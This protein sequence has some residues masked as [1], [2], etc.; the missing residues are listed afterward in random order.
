[1]IFLMRAAVPCAKTSRW[2]ILGQHPAAAPLAVPRVLHQGQSSTTA[3]P[4][5]WRRR[6]AAASNARHSVEPLLSDQQS[7]AS[8]VAVDV[9]VGQQPLVGWEA[10]LS[11]L[12]PALQRL[13]HLHSF[14]VFAVPAGAPESVGHQ[15]DDGVTHSGSAGASN[16]GVAA[17]S[18]SSVGSASSNSAT[19]AATCLWADFLPSD[20]TSRVTAVTLLTGGAVPGTLRARRLPALPHT[21]PSAPLTLT[22]VATLQLPGATSGRLDTADTPLSAAAVQKPPQAS[23]PPVVAPTE[24]TAA[25]SS[26]SSSASIGHPQEAAAGAQPAAPDAA[27]SCQRTEGT[28][29]AKGG[30]R[31][32][33]PSADDAIARAEALV[34]CFNAGWEPR[35]TLLRNDCRAYAKGLV[36]YALL[37]SGSKKP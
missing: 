30:R 33:G 9:Y 10:L 31:V 7:P 11:P 34:L 21:S 5:S 27:A 23:L 22:R 3:P 24:A 12:P 1:M 16:G 29:H 35:V 32:V 20:P 28:G 15:Q 37:A 8:S 4:R 13:L 36:N 26:R 18:P 14:V 19:A 6:G 25:S 17:A 2:L